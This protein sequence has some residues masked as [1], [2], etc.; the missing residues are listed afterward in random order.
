MDTIN[1]LPIPSGNEHF[2]HLETLKSPP[3]VVD[4]LPQMS[5]GQILKCVIVA[6]MKYTGLLQM[7]KKPTFSP[8]AATYNTLLLQQKKS[9]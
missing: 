4:M 6:M 9:S 2:L 7:W 3:I 1:S 8:E 5:A